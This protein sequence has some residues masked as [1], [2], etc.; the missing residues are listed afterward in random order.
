MISVTNFKESTTSFP[1]QKTICNT[2]KSSQASALSISS[3][4]GSS[5]LSPYQWSLLSAFSLETAGDPLLIF[6]PPSNGLVSLSSLNKSY[7]CFP[8]SLF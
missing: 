1:A 5:L 4:P 8:I 6:L 3:S 2:N 7:P